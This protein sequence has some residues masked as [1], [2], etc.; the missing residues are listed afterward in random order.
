M[1]RRRLLSIAPPALLLLFLVVPGVVQAQGVGEWLLSTLWGIVAGFLGF[2]L[3]LAALFLNASV[4]LFVIG[5]GNLYTTTGLGIAIDS[6]W[7]IIR[8]VMNLAFIFGLLYIGIKIILNSDDSRARALL[9]NLIIAALLVN[10]SLFISKF[11]VDVSNALGAEIVQNGFPESSIDESAS[12]ANTGGLYQ[13]IQTVDIGEQF[14]DVLNIT[15]LLNGKGVHIA[16]ILGAAVFL[17][18]SIFVFAAGAVMLSI[19]FAVLNLYIALSPLMFIGWAFP[20]LQKYTGEYWRGFLNRAFFAPIYL[21][22]LYL[23][24]VVLGNMGASVNTATMVGNLEE[25]FPDPGAAAGGFGPETATQ[26]A[27]SIIPFFVLSCIFLIASLVIASKM[28]AQG[29]AGAVSLGSRWSKG[30]GNYAK[31]Q[32]LR[33]TGAATFGVAGRVGQRT[34]GAGADR[35]AKSSRFQSFA[36]NR[37]IGEYLYKAN[38]GLADSSFDARRVGGFGKATGLGDGIK[39]GYKSRQEEA[40]KKA[41]EFNEM[42]KADMDTTQNQKRKK[43][44]EDEARAEQTKINAISENAS[45]SKDELEKEI[46]DLNHSIKIWQARLDKN[47]AEGGSLY[48]EKEAA[49]KRKEIEDKKQSRDAKQITLDYNLNKANIEKEIA[50]LNAQFVPGQSAAEKTAIREQIDKKQAELEAA[51]SLDTKEARDASLANAMAREENAEGE[52]E[53]SAQVKYQQ[54]LKGQIGRF[55]T[56]DRFPKEM[57]EAI[58]KKQGVKDMVKS[59]SEIIREVMRQPGANAMNKKELKKAFAEAL[60]ENNKKAAIAIALKDKSNKA[61]TEQL[62]KLSKII[63]ESKDNKSGSD[64]DS[65]KNESWVF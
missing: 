44:I 3:W 9:A 21:F 4:N 65:D 64:A 57:L 6:I 34:I 32:T 13:N 63:A 17:I 49:E 47:D 54:G 31:K 1:N 61:Q 16:F 45:K 24:L 41:V 55:G 26:A 42:L 30:V 58:E 11:V 2:F 52:V 8:D 38:K 22:M 25:A 10:F 51:S 12:G 40:A 46:A 48:T 35:L 5:F 37:K 43:A 14:M 7:V 27:L 23:S 53:R 59:R 56:V 18:I 29:A 39:G 15:S 60:E 28:G 20:P 33:G 50:D 36:A 19:R 62:K